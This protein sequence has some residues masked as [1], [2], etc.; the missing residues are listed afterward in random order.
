M[1]FASYNGIEA[2]SWVNSTTAKCLG[3][4]AENLL[5]GR[6]KIEKMFVDLRVS[7]KNISAPQG[8]FAAV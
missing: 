8:V 3:E 2:V 7:S 6:K 1:R 5:T 4:G